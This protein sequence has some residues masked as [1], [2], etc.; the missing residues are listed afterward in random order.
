MQAPSHRLE[1]DDAIVLYILY[2]DV[3]AELL[4]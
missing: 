2:I 1:R 3:G 4:Q